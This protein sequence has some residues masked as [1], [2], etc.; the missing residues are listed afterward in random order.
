MLRMMLGLHLNPSISSADT[1][2]D[3]KAFIHAIILFLCFEM[4]KW[5]EPKQMHITGK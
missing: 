3:N 4:E 5:E 1:V 2:T